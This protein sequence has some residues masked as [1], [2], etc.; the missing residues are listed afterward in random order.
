MT[1]VASAPDPDPGLT[2]APL[3]PGRLTLASNFA[4]ASADDWTALAS[5]VLRR[6]GVAESSDPRQNLSVVNE[7]GITV[8][9]LYTRAESGSA[10]V[11]APGHQ[12]FVRGASGGPRVGWDVRAHHRDSDPVR[13]NQAILGDLECGV[14]SVW[15]ALG[16]DAI[17]VPD[18][19]RALRGV[20]LDLTPIVLDAGVDVAQAAQALLDLADERGVSRAQLRGSL[21]ADPVAARARSGAPA[22][23]GGLARLAGMTAGTGLVAV[24]VD[25]TVYNDAGGSDSDELAAAASAG[26]AYVRALSKAGVE[27]PF[28]QL[29]FRY[30]VGD[31]QFAAIVKLRAAR[32]IW[33][34]IGELSGVS[35]PQRQHA[36]TSAAMMTRRD[37]WVNILR[38]TIAC[39]AAAVG[40]A[41]AITVRPFDDALGLPDNFARRI[42]RNTQAI[43]HDEAHLGRVAD[44]AGGSWYV[45]TLTGDL[46]EAAWDKFTALEREGATPGA[47][48]SGALGQLLARS[49][50][51]RQAALDTRRV[52]I[53]GVTS[54]PNVVE[55]AVVRPAA[56][57][58]A[59]GL[60][61]SMRHAEK[62]EALRDRS[63][64][65]LQTTGARPR[66]L[67]ATL[68]A[69]AAYTA[70]VDFA[71]EL[72]Q[73]AGVVTTLHAVDADVPLSSDI[74][75]VACL[76][77]SDPV[78]A[79]DAAA[80]VHRLRAAGVARILVV[81]Q[82]PAGCDVDASVVA[83]SNVLDVLRHTLDA[84]E[85]GL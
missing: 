62:F 21:G 58:M 6:S 8:Q 24:T 27:D 2:G 42:A 68:G 82:S 18:L 26:V 22:D 56:A 41:D 12:P 17:T 80:A 13:T 15:L 71:R 79:G 45:D 25:G 34:R 37:P 3:A 1:T 36:V 81:G 65:H 5:A 73:I 57:P 29:E 52:R 85:V 43:V 54:F 61:P 35:A 72:F 44:P 63:D 51:A 14:T 11:G 76:C 78:Y 16:P 28:S 31:D 50:T 9:P 46:A 32:Q 84:L 59:G 74:D 53:T 23:L 19:G 77:S 60:L 38:T 70:R 39:F 64:R 7:D 66:I 55:A 33:S 4:P 20:P 48:E 75:H 83:G 47:L 40:G 10:A 49:S 69:P 67:L 30:A